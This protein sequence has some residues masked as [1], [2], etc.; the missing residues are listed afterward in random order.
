MEIQ[1]PSPS[2]FLKKS[3]V[4]EPTSTLPTVKKSVKSRITTTTTKPAGKP[5]VAA[6]GTQD[7]AITKPKQ[8]KSRNGKELQF[9]SHN[10]LPPLLSTHQALKDKILKDISPLQTDLYPANS[11]SSRLHDMQEKAIKM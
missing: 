9:L 3:P 4:L 6:G 7:G 5:T 11:N 10:P 8:S 1:I 2:V